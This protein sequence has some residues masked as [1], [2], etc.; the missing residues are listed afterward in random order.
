MAAPH[1]LRG[2]HC[3]G[4]SRL[5]RRSS[6][7][8]FPLWTPSGGEHRASPRT[9]STQLMACSRWTGYNL[10]RCQPAS[11]STRFHNSLFFGHKPPFPLDLSV[12]LSV[13]PFNKLPQSTEALE[14]GTNKTLGKFQS[15]RSHI[16]LFQ[17]HAVNNVATL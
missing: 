10:R 3:S 4:S 15:K 1:W 12:R 6:A 17:Q 8:T 7:A 16:D 13:R 2:S 14:L 11:I 5:Q 9:N